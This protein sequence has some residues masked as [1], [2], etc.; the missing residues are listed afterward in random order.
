MTRLPRHREL[1]AALQNRCLRDLRSG[2]RPLSTPEISPVV[3]TKGISARRSVRLFA[4][5]TAG[6]REQWGHA[7]EG[8]KIVPVFAGVR[9]GGSS[10][11]L[12]L[13]FTLSLPLGLGGGRETFQLK[14]FK[15]TVCK[16]F[17][18]TQICWRKGQFLPGWAVGEGCSA[19]AGKQGAELKSICQAEDGGPDLTSLPAPFPA[20]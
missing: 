16:V 3:H 17:K 5:W 14:A 15:L 8:R 2:A 4:V 6:P 20:G 18:P 1:V 10:V 9:D 13:P 19:R 12:A 7:A 11:L